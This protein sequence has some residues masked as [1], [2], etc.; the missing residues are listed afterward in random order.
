[1]IVNRKLSNGIRVVIESV[2]NVR[3]AALGIY[4]ETGSAYETL[5]QNGISHMLEHMM[6]KGTANRS[7]RDIAR[8]TALLGDDMNAY[9]AKEMTCYYARVLD[10][11]LPVMAEL[12]GDMLTNSLFSEEDLEREKGVILDEIDM[13][14]D[15][16]EDLV[17]EQL[18]KLVWEEHAL[19]FIISGTEENVRRISR[20]ELIEFWREHYTAQRMLLSVAGNVEIEAVCELLERCFS[21]IPEGSMSVPAPAPIYHPGRKWFHKEMEQVHLCVGFPSISHTD[22]RSYTLS[23]VNNIIGGS[24]SSRLFQRIREEQGLCYSLYSYGSSYHQ[25]GI[26]QIYCGMNEENLEIVCHEIM[27]A[28]KQ[29]AKEGPDL[30]ELEQSYLQI[31]SELLLSMENTHNRMNHN[32][33]CLLYMGRIVSIEEM[34]GELKKVQKEDVIAYM[35]NFCKPELASWTLVGDLEENPELKKQFDS[36]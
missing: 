19:G 34:L 31:R 32:A 11:H 26:F 14:E 28:L 6:F 20:Q 2:P 21:G 10:E 7:A 27:E 17:Q 33:R 35:E 5:E 16:P 25:T 8:E 24:S 15:S 3:S 13:Y 4:V 1:M 18:Q 12:M 23:M 9:T 29:F 22:S 36:F 30:E